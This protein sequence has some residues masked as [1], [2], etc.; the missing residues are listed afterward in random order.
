MVRKEDSINIMCRY[1]N[2]F[3]LCLE[4]I[5]KIQGSTVSKED[6]SAGVLEAKTGI[7]FTS[8]GDIITIK[9]SKINDDRTKVDVSSCT[10]AST[11]LFDYGKNQKNVDAIIAF[12]K[13]Y[14]TEALHAATMP[15]V[16]GGSMTATPVIIKEREVLI[17]CSY[18]ASLNEHG[19]TTCKSCGGSL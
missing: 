4:A 12:L 6:R 2:S 16:Q 3:E 11:V 1:E 19:L 7:T 17:R 13:P 5:K 14:G 18:C 10:A 8:L 15:S 9:L